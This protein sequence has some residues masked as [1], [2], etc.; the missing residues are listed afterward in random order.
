MVAQKETTAP[1]VQGAQFGR[2]E[3]AGWCGRC[4]SL[5]GLLCATGC[6]GVGVLKTLLEEEFI[7]L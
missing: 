1:P 2:V 6:F 4:W 3:L 5:L 7:S